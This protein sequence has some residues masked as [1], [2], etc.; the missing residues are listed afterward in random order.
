MLT[1]VIVK[2]LFT[3]LL[4]TWSEQL[5]WDGRNGWS[6]YYL[7]C[8]FHLTII[9]YHKTEIQQVVYNNAK[10]SYSL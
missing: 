6:V 9:V 8:K 3:F 2:I 7:N 10:L 5:A 4:L 1:A